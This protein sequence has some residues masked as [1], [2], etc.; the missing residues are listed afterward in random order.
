MKRETTEFEAIYRQFRMPLLRFIRYK[1]SDAHAAEDLLQ[2]VFIKASHSLESLKD[3]KKIQSWLFRIA[4]NTIID[5]Y[6]KHRI[7]LSD[8]TDVAQ[9]VE[10][11]TVLQEL[12]CCIGPFLE[13][14]P[15]AQHAAMQAI[16]LH[17]Q[18]E[19]EYASQ[20]ELNLST[21]KS[22]VRRAKASMK[23]FFE[24]CCSF[25]RN[26]DNEVVDFRER[27]CKRCK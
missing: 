20:N 4:S 5:Y 21:V 1:I 25:E 27:D 22:Q 12:S 18:T 24:A 19:A 7:P 8:E 10:S 15:S 16:Y 9:D 13:A 14:L 3:E 2:E 6:R 26:K 11:E 17:E 23:L